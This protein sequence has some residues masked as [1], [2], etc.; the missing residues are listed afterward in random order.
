MVTQ[1]TIEGNHELMVVHQ[2]LSVCTNLCIKI[3]E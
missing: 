2:P 3:P 1:L